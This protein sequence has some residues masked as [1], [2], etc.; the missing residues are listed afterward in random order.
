MDQDARATAQATLLSLA[1]RLRGY[2]HLLMGNLEDADDALQEVFVKY[3]SRPPSPES[4]AAEG[5]LFQVARN[6]A[7]NAMRSARR[8]QRR[9]RSARAP[10]P[11]PPE[12]PGEA[13]GRREA[14]RRMDA[15]LHRLALEYR[16]PLYL[17]VVE[18]LSVREIAARLGVPKSTVASRVREALVLLNRAF[19]TVS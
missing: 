19:Q 6:A 12:D 2:L 14:V 4:P 18:G 1:P 11:W 8:R 3:L 7:L 15:A 16:E 13:A 5:W 9:E 17:N 10:L